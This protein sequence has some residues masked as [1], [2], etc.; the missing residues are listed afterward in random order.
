MS[1]PTLY[2]WKQYKSCNDYEK[3]LIRDSFIKDFEVTDRAF[4]NI[5]KNPL[6]TKHLIWLLKTFGK[7]E[8]ASVLLTEC[9]AIP[10]Q[11][12]IEMNPEPELV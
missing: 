4:R 11:T 8:F 9:P 1:K 3:R 5:L 6:Q 10:L 2:F 7:P 12:L